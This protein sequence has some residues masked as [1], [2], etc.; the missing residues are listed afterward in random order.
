MVTAS[1]NSAPARQPNRPIEQSTMA[2]QITGQRRLLML[3]EIHSQDGQRS[4]G[5][6]Y[7]L[8]PDGMFVLSAIGPKLK[9]KYVEIVLPAATNTPVRIVG[10]VIHCWEYGFRLLFR[11]LDEVA[12]SFIRSCLLH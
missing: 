2:A 12:W 10:K 5:L 3:A 8:G 4:S 1:E 9:D 11:E 6:V 7:D